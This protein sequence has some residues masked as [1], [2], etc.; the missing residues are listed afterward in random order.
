ATV[1][2]AL[3][4]LA[5]RAIHC[6]DLAGPRTMVLQPL[7]V[8]SDLRPG[9]RHVSRRGPGRGCAA[10]YRLGKDDLSTN[11]RDY[12]GTRLV[13]LVSGSDQA[14]GTK[15]SIPQWKK[16]PDTDAA[17]P[18]SCARRSVLGILPLFRTV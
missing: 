16:L 11:C 1:V 17:D 12:R 9:L 18:I 4:R 10:Q 6:S 14:A 15:A 2:G 7:H 3:F 13:Q 8:A 5:D